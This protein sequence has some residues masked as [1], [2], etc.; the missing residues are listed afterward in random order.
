M[1]FSRTAI[2][3]ACVL[4][5]L[6]SVSA[7]SFAQAAS[8]QI[9]VTAA[10][11]AQPVDELPFGVSVITADD[12][13]SAGVTTVNE[14]LMKLLGVQGRLDFYGGGDYSLDLRGFG[15]TADVNQVI[16]LDGV[17][18]NEADLSGTRLAGIPID[19][20]ERIEVIRG[21]AAVLYGEGASGGVISVT[22]KAAAGVARRNAANL[23]AA[24][25]SYGLREARGSGTVVLGEFSFD[26]SANKRQADNHRQNFRS[27]VEGGALAAQWQHEQLRA[28][29]RRSYDRL[30]TGL[31]GGLTAAQYA[32][33]PS[34]TGTPQHHGTIRNDLTTAFARADLQGWE[35]AL[36]LGWRD[37]SLNDVDP[38]QG[39]FGTYAY[40]VDARTQALRARRGF[41]TGAVK[42]DLIAGVDRNHWRRSTT[43][44]TA[45]QSSSAVYLKDALTLTTGTRID[46][47]ARTESLKKSDGGSGTNLD[48]RQNAWEL[49]LTQTLGAGW[50]VYG[51]AGRS[52]RLANVDEFSFFT[53]TPIQPQ[54]SRDLE[55]GTRWHDAKTRVELRAYR[56]TLRH[57][58]GFDP[59]AANAFGGTGAN[60]N[61]DPTRRQGVEAEAKTAVTPTLD[62]G[63]N[64]AL[65]Q[66]RFTEGPYNGKNVPMTAKTSAAVRA[67]WQVLP[68]HRVDADLRYVSSASPDFDNICKIPGYTT[69][70][71]RYAFQH[72]PVELALGVANATDRR[73]YTQAFRCVGGQT[74]SIYPEAGRAFTASARWQF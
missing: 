74:S 38:A 16:V 46:I 21:S 28:G 2:A 49:G 3:R 50:A 13:R 33:D 37:K 72:G 48:D 26:A 23:Y 27:E 35:L 57:E 42:H 10:R 61:F 68:Q 64:L 71:L 19:T 12:L 29:V 53:N 65:R 39:P 73:Y 44:G 22:T 1:S 9:I 63:L 31:P 62:L 52:F 69:L 7:S 36:D 66:A 18:L 58:I 55:L 5:G 40:D 11:F 8:Q 59:N 67:A 4:A 14:A 54:T 56:S 25:G 24:A 15:A 17:K 47:G 51:R 70:D 43:Y 30:S 20:V 45:A 41:D 6:A 60:T 34:Q 32:A